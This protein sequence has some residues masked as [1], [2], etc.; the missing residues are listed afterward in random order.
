MAI[1]SSVIAG[2]C[3]AFLKYNKYPA[4]IIMGDSGSNFLG[5]ALS[6]ITIYS[7]KNFDSSI[8]LHYAIS[9]RGCCSKS[10]PRVASES[11]KINFH[12]HA[13]TNNSLILFNLNQS[14][15]ML[16]RRKIYHANYIQEASI[17][18]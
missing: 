10:D 15:I 4:K 3:L 13:I 9:V 1:F 6:I 12:T 5:F 11:P 2:S 16:K 14:N 17:D 7:F 8:N 18:S